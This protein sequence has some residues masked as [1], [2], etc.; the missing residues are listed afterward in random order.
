MVKALLGK[1]T[2]LWFSFWSLP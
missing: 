1:K 2:C